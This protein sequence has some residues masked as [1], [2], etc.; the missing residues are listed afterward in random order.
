[1]KNIT[2]QLL[3]FASASA[4][5]FLSGVTSSSAQT[6]ATVP[7]G[8]V[9]VTIAAGTG[10]VFTQTP[11]SAPLLTTVGVAGQANGRITAV[12]ASTITNSAA[13]WTDS[14]LA[15]LGNPYFINFRSGANAGRMFQITANTAT[16]LTVN[17]QSLDLTTLGFV[18][19]AS[20]DSYEIVQGDTILGILGTTA[21]GVVGGTSTQFNAGTVDRVL[22]TDPASGSTFSYYFDTSVSQW[23]RAGSGVNQGNL[24]VSPKSGLNYF[25]IANTAIT[26]QFLGNAPSTASKHQIPTIGTTIVSNYFPTDTTLAGLNIDNIVGWRKAN[27]SGVTVATSDKVVLRVSGIYYSY[28]FDASLTQWRRAGSSLNQSGVSV[29]TGAAIRFVRS[30]SS[31]T[32]TW[33]TIRPY[34][35]N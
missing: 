1:V 23:R 14:A 9:T 2:P 19:G 20:G 21:N 34:A 6:V 30:G 29:P 5:A 24:V 17:P 31:G 28:W 15:T 33:D 8:A 4:L 25:R 10:T 12:G 11:F 7:A 27:E 35:L 16:Q 3:A 13:G 32:S 26:L 18:V 22:V